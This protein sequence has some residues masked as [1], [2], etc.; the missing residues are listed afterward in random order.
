MQIRILST[1]ILLILLSSNYVYADLT[2]KDI[3]EIR[4][5]VKEEVNESANS[6]RNEMNAR[7]KAVNERID[8]L[9]SDIY[10]RF[11]G[12]ARLFHWLYILLAGIIALNGAMVGSVVWLAMQDRPIAKKHYDTIIAREDE[13]EAKL[14]QLE[15]LLKSH[16]ELAHAK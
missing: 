9:R 8:D 6:L 5:I 11:D 12:I 16:L 7:F 10:K 2:K 13:F 3:E 1:I 15:K 4:R 14:S